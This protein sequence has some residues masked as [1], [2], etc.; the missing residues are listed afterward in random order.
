MVGVTE[1][2]TDDDVVVLMLLVGLAVMVLV[3]LSDPLVVGVTL[4]DA[5]EL[6]EAVGEV[7]GVTGTAAGDSVGDMELDPDGVVVTCT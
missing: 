7:V 6:R 3:E 1:G 5:P 4:G 2:V